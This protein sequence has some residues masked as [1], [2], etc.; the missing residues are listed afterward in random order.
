[1]EAQAFQDAVVKLGHLSINGMSQGFIEE[2]RKVI[3]EIYNDMASCKHIERIRS[4]YYYDQGQILMALLTTILT[5]EGIDW[6]NFT[7]PTE[8]MDNGYHDYKGG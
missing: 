7:R 2:Y 4:G 8:Y 3:T 6:Q 5:K 1:M